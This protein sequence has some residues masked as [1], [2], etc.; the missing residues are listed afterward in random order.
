MILALKAL[1]LLIYG[2]QVTTVGTEGHGEKPCYTLLVHAAR[3]IGLLLS[4][5]R[6]MAATLA[7]D[8][9]S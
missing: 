5:P 8:H 4:S 3:R 6:N 7:S 9:A 2:A 1:G